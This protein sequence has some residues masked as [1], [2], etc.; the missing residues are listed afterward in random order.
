MFARV[1]WLPLAEAPPSFAM[2]GAGWTVL[3]LSVG[4]VLLLVAFC[5]RRVLALPTVEMDDLHGPL[6]IDTRDTVDAD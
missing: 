5:L 1:V 3:T 6:D 2:N 4:S